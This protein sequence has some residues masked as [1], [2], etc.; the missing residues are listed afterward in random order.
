[1]RYRYRWG[2][3]TTATDETPMRYARDAQERRRLMR[4]RFD[5]YIDKLLSKLRCSCHRWDTDTNEIS[6]IINWCNPDEISNLIWYWSDNDT[7][8]IL[9]RYRFCHRWNTCSIPIRYRYWWY[10]YTYHT[11]SDT[12]TYHVPSEIHTPR[13]QKCFERD[14]ERDMAKMSKRSQ[15]G[16]LFR[17]LG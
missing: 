13:E 9:I 4:C 10:T 11:D 8:E 15:S 17:D 5:T 12:D 6:V 7:D 3:D 14:F 2:T 16:E 1:M